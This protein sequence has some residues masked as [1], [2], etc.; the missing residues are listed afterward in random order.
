MAVASVA[1][2]LMLADLLFLGGDMLT[3]V[4]DILYTI[5]VL[6]FIPTNNWIWLGLWA[7]IAYL[8]VLLSHLFIWNKFL[9]VIVNRYIAPDREK[10]LNERLIGRTG[11]VSA[12]NGLLFIHV[13]DEFLRCIPE[14]TDTLPTEYPFNARIVRWDTTQEICVIATAME[15][16]NNVK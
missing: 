8:A 15:A 5:I 14:N 12:E 7:V 2:T 6:H 3:Y 11:M 13:G 16:N 1:V 4:A 10:I 9:S